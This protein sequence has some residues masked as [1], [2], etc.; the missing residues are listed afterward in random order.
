MKH[1][2]LFENFDNKIVLYHGSSVEF[3]RFDMSKLSP[4][5]GNDTYGWGMY[6]TDAKAFAEEY[7]IDGGFL[8]KITLDKNVEKDFLNF[9]EY[10]N[11]Y[12]MN[13][14]Q[15]QLNKENIDIDFT[16]E[17]VDEYGDKVE[18][19]SAWDVL[20]YIF[21]YYFETYPIKKQF[22]YGR[23]TAK[24]DTSL[25]MLR[26]GI[27]GLRYKLQARHESEPE[28]GHEGFAYV[29]Y[30]EDLINNNLEKI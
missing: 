16:K 22:S 28:W 12:L 14:I 29:I 24:K 23:N 2:Q 7:S 6:V 9:N 19:E 30:D 18:I 20:S 3:D 5:M 21:N 11:T 25:F 13:K 26:S 15:A 4:K 27:K 17:I 8:Y 1:L 10:P